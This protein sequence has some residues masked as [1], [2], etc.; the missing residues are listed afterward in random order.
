MNDANS[1]PGHDVDAAGSL[2]TEPARRRLSGSKKLMIAF[3]ILVS[4]L[5]LIWTSG[6]SKKE[7]EPP[8]PQPTVL[9]DAE[10]FRPAPIEV[11][12]E[13]PP[14]EQA[15][16]PAAP[17]PGPSSAELHGQEVVQSPI[18]AYDSGDQTAGIS[19]PREDKQNVTSLHAAEAS[20]ENDLST[21]MKPGVQ[22]PTR[23]RLLP[24]PDFMISQGTV[25]PCILQ[26]AIDTSLPGYVKCVLP[27]D[28]RGATNNVVLLDRGTTVIGEVQ[29]GL[30]QGDARVFVIWNRAET[31]NHAVVSLASP[32]ADELGRSGMPG[33][34]DNHFWQ[35][36][37]G[38]M[39]LNV[40]QGAF[41]AANQYADSSGGG[42][43]VNNF[44]SN[45]GQTVDTALRATVN[46]PPSLKKNQGDAV[47]IFVARDLDFSDIYELQATTAPMRGISRRR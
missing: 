11:A 37:G 6:H 16:Q 20:V 8:P 13:P 1:Q 3:L 24:H 23:A 29:H 25:I 28:V 47:S 21:R 42:P 31:P 35:R 14:P 4:S 30:Q 22:E 12:P 10:P 39:L 46:I 5:S 41:Q 18:F 45:G 32:G 43:S 33:T 40:V 34:V 15:V 26:T 44:Q 38:A 27:Q 36:F 9:T 7:G 17:A 19:R 2:V